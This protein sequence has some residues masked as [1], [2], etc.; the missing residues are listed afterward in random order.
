MISSLQTTT[1]NPKYL[2]RQ[3]FETNLALGIRAVNLDVIAEGIAGR[4]RVWEDQGSSGPGTN[5]KCEERRSGNVRSRSVKALNPATYQLRSWSD[6]K[7]WLVYRFKPPSPSHPFWQKLPHRINAIGL[8]STAWAYPSNNLR[9]AG[10][11]RGLSNHTSERTTNETWEFAKTVGVYFCYSS[12]LYLVTSWIWMTN[13]FFE[14]DCS[15]SQEID[16]AM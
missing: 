5:T 2:I 14:R 1:S 16:V 12:T 9:R 7:D 4:G 15:S 3:G 8:Y 6:K 10:I 13:L 11:V